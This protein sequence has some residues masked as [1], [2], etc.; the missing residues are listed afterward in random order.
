MN[1]VP[2]LNGKLFQVYDSLEYTLNSIA[3][4]HSQYNEEH[5]LFKEGKT[6]FI[7]LLVDE[8]E[9]AVYTNHAI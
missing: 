9:K 6:N 1:H 8:D 4:M 2:A 3:S 7:Y 5:S